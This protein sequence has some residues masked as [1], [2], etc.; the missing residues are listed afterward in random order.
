MGTG[1]APEW[2]ID[3]RL[4]LSGAGVGRRGTMLGDD[5]VIADGSTIMQALPRPTPR[6]R[7]PDGR[8][9]PR[10]RHRRARRAAGHG[11]R[12]PR[13]ASSI[14]R[15]A[16]R[17]AR[18]GRWFARAAGRRPRARRRCAGARPGPRRRSG[19]RSRQRRRGGCGRAAGSVVI[20]TKDTRDRKPCDPSGRPAS[21]VAATSP[22]ARSRRSPVPAGASTGCRTIA[23]VVPASDDGVAALQG[24]LRPERAER[25]SARIQGGPRPGDAGR[26]EGV[27]P[28]RDPLLGARAA[29]TRTSVARVAR[30]SRRP[31]RSRDSARRT[32]GSR[33]SSSRRSAATSR[34]AAPRSPR[35]RSS[36]RARLARSAASASA[37]S[38]T[39]SSAAADGVGA[40]TSAAKSASVTSTSCPTPH[41]TGT[42]CATIARTTRSSLNDHRSSSD[43]PPRARIVTAGASAW[44][45]SRAASPIQRSRRRRA[46]T[47]LAGAPSPWTW[48]ATST[49][50]A[51]GQRR[52]S[53]LHTSRQTA[54]VGEVTTAITGGRSGSG[55]LRAAS[56]RPSAERRALSCSKRMARSPKPDG[57]RDST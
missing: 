13:G 10:A 4:A 17:R 43:P 32:A 56:N 24:R 34:T 26:G 52:A 38:G 44:R 47:M 11:A 5:Y 42:G 33:R 20:G 54:P 30:S 36:R 53:T 22:P 23:P 6:R 28:A 1:A 51:S 40:R 31:A 55:R 3:V 39:T 19:S 49:T 21:T 41:T 15:G 9:P 25:G 37:R 27:L 12:R 7:P 48:H 35:T 57:W 46:P 50:R 16:R 8:R 45:P 14:V 18:R 2:R 29:P